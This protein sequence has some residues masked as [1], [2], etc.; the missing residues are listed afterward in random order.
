MA[1]GASSI[2]SSQRRPGKSVI[3]TS[4][5]APVPMQA[6]PKPTMTISNSVLPR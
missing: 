5:A 4:Q 2:H 1:S 6:V 3:T